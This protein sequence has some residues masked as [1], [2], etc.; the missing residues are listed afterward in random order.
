MGFELLALPAREELRRER[1]S[2][3]GGIRGE[4]SG[5]RPWRGQIAYAPLHHRVSPSGDRTSCHSLPP[6]QMGATSPTARSA[7]IVWL[8]R[9]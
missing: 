6:T 2:A 8:D 4:P 9:L 7:M 3:A 1:M 5:P